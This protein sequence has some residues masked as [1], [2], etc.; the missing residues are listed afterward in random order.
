[1]HHN[2]AAFFSTSFKKA[3]TIKPIANY[4][5]SIYTSYALKI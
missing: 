1:M 5:A 4:D 3:A 2:L